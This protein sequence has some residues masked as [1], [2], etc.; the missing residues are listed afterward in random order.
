MANRIS[1][2]CSLA[3]LLSSICGLIGCNATIVQDESEEFIFD[4]DDLPISSEITLSLAEECTTRYKVCNGASCEY[5]MP[6]NC[7]GFTESETGSP[8][9]MDYVAEND[10]DHNILLDYQVIAV[11]DN[12]SGETLFYEEASLGLALAAGMSF[13]AMVSCAAGNSFDTLATNI[14]DA[15]LM[16]VVIYEDENGEW[17]QS[18]V[19]EEFYVEEL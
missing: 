5:N 12:S 15:S 8:V 7:Y 19:V 6:C 4:L 14:E 3:F 17:V 18:R 11:I 9:M 10:S 16:F 13:S 1:S 2:M